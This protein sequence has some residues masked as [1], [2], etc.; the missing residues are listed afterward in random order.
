MKISDQ[1][2]SFSNQTQNTSLTYDTVFMI[3][4]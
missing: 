2:K 4:K 1:L 3:Y